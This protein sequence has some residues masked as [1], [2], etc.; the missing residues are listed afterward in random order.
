L[1]DHGQLGAGARCVIYGRSIARSMAR[2]A[3]KRLPRTTE[4][5]RDEYHAG[6]WARFLNEKR[7][8]CVPD[9]LSLLKGPKDV[10]IVANMHGQPTRMSGGT[11]YSYRQEALRE[12]FQ[13]EFTDDIDIVEIGAGW[14]YNIFSMA[15]EF[16]KRHFLGLEISEHAVAA[17]RKIAA[18]FGIEDRVSFDLFDATRTDD[19]GWKTLTGRGCFTFFCIEQLPRAVKSVISN[20]LDARPARVLHFEPHGEISNALNPADW[21]NYLYVRSVDYQTDLLPILRQF[22]STGAIRLLK[23]EKLPFSPTIDNRGCF[24]A[25]QPAD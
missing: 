17:G 5:V 11:Y 21:A 8:E 19:P 25:W 14:G 4:R 2:L 16:P 22:D 9:L 7:W 18:H 3:L 10:D 15:L 24:V 6:H 13:R 20:I 23:T 1:A 12:I